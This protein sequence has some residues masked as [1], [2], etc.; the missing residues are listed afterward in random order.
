MR[1][2]VCLGPI[3]NRHTIWMGR[4]Q[5]HMVIDSQFCPINRSALDAPLFLHLLI[6]TLMSVYFF[7]TKAT[8]VTLFSSSTKSMAASPLDNVATLG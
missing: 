2:L 5:A 3:I 6:L 1:H 4:E 7:G 8:S